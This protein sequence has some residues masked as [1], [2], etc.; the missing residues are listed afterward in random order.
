MPKGWTPKRDPFREQIK[1]MIANAVMHAGDKKRLA[2]ETGLNYKRLIRIIKDIDRLELG[3]IITLQRYC[4]RKG[5][6]GLH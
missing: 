2:D 4:E 3:E 1:G 6:N 5:I